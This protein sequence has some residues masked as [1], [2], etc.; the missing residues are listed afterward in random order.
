MLFLMTCN[1][2]IIISTLIG[3]YIGYLLFISKYK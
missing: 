1:G 2:W 3:Y